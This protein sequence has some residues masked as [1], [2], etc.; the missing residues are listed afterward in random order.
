MGS[1]RGEHEEVGSAKYGKV[2]REQE[3]GAVYKVGK[4]KGEQEEE[5]ES[6]KVGR[7]SVGR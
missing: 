5:E 6:A 7:E 4:G 2:Y 3:K 1:E